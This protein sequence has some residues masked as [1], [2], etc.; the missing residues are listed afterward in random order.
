MSI[1][2]QKNDSRKSGDLLEN[3]K[4]SKTVWDLRF[5]RGGGD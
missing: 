5:E 3:K 2:T 4:I 1:K